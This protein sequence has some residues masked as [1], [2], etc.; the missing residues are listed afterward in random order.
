MRFIR[1]VLTALAMTLGIAGADV[2][3]AVADDGSVETVGGAVRLMKPHSSIRMVSETVKARVRPGLA[4]VDCEFVMRNE[5]PTDTVLVGFPDGV[6]G[7]YMGGGEEHEIEGFRSW[8]DGV[9]AKCQRVSAAEVQVAPSAVGS[10]WTKLVV[11]PAGAVRRIRNH[12]AVSPSW[13][14]SLLESEVDSIAG[15]RTFRYILWTGASWKGPIG[16]AEIAVTLVGIPPERVT[17]TIPTARQVGRT[18]RWSFRDFEPGV[19]EE[20]ERVELTWRVHQ[21]DVRE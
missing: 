2:V 5:G 16:R 9:E 1:V 8:V 11:F 6:M 20:P 10:W 13:H 7:P 15:E 12:Y 17:G 19:G 3:R 4:I 14:P 21:A 18:F